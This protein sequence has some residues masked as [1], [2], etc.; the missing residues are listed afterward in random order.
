[1]PAVDVEVVVNEC[2]GRRVVDLLSLAVAG[3]EMIG[4]GETDCGK[5]FYCGAVEVA[6]GRVEGGESK[7]VRMKLKG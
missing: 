3:G 6:V 2:D 1:M 5:W 7:A 4:S